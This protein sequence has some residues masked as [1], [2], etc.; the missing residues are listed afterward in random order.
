MFR[1]FKVCTVYMGAP[2]QVRNLAPRSASTSPAAAFQIAYIESSDRKAGP[3]ECGG[4][5]NC[6]RTRSAPRKLTFHFLQELFP[7]PMNSGQ[8]LVD[9][10]MSATL[11]GGNKALPAPPVQSSSARR[12]SLARR[13][14]PNLP[15]ATWVLAMLSAAFHV[16]G[17]TKSSD[18]A[19]ASQMVPDS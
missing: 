19:L 17:S 15:T 18:K 11:T 4:R 8:G 16:A 10:R 2:T 1:H 9:W 5:Y 13:G 6:T 3:A 7:A 14:V 12:P